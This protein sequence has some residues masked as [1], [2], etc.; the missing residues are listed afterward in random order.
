MWRIA[1]SH[2]ECRRVEGPAPLPWA[3]AALVI[4]V[5]SALCWAVLIGLGWAVRSLFL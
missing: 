2:E 1:Q 5:L 4:G 3:Q